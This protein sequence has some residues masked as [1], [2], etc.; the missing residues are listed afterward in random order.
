MPGTVISLVAEGDD[1]AVGQTVAIV[2]AMKMEHMLVASAAG[3]VATVH[4]ARVTVRLDE[5]VVTIAAAAA[6]RRAST[7]TRIVRDARRSGRGGSTMSGW[8]LSDEHEMLRRVREFAEAE[9]APACAQWDLDHHFPVDVVAAMGDPDSSGSSS[10]ERW[11]G[12]GRHPR[13]VAIE[14]LGRADQSMG[15]TLSAG[16]GLRQPIHQFG[17]DEQ[18][19]RWLPDLVAGRIGRVGLTE[20]DGSDAGA[21]CTKARS[22]ATNG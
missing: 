20:P 11:G 13:R 14:E 17:T 10:P 19:D 12:A 1:V 16:V 8:E 7:S 21:T 22:T 6:R 4:A 2:E 3:V 5:P 18:R 15:I 9:I